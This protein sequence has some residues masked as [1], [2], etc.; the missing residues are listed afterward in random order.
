MGCV[1]SSLFLAR[2]NASWYA[3]FDIFITSN[4]QKSNKYKITNTILFMHM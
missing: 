4:M 3:S 1:G 2:A